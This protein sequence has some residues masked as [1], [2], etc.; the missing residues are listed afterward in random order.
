MDRLRVPTA[1]RV[2]FILTTPSSDV[3]KAA[4]LVREVETGPDGD[5]DPNRPLAIVKVNGGHGETLPAIPNF[6][7]LT[8]KQ[9]FEGL[10]RPRSQQSG[11][12]IFPRLRTIS[13]SSPSRASSPNSSARITLLRS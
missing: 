10:A 12:C 8:T 7:A 1:G 11:S 5:N 2:E 13:S 6:K 4:L 9:R 3:K